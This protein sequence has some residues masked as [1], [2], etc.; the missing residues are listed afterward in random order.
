MDNQ[1]FRSIWGVAF[2]LFLSACTSVPLNSSAP[3][4][5]PQADPAVSVDPA[6]GRVSDPSAPTT[7]AVELVVK[8]S[9]APT[10]T[11]RPPAKLDER[12]RTLMEGDLTALVDALDQADPSTLELLAAQPPSEG[13]QV[14]QL[15][16]AMIQAHSGLPSVLPA[17]VPERFAGKLDQLRAMQAQLNQS[18]PRR[19]GLLLP[20]DRAWGDVLEKAFRFGLGESSVEVVVA[21]SAEPEA[22]MR[23]LVLNQGA[24][25]VICG[26]FLKRA[27]RAA[28][29]AQRYGVPIVSLAREPGM[30]SLGDRVFQVGLT[31]EAQI[32]RLVEGAMEQRNYKRFAILFPRTASG[33]SAAKRF[34]AQVEARG[35]EVIISQ[36]YPRGETTF[37]PLISGMVGRDA[38]SLNANPK[39]RKCVSEIDDELKGLRRKRR[40]ESCRDRT[41]PKVEFEAIFVPDSVASVRQIMPFIELADMVPNLNER[42]LWK[43]RKATENKELVATPILGMRQ[44]N[45]HYFASRSRTDVEGSLFVDAYYPY[46]GERALPGQFT[47]AFR[48]LNNRPP[49]LLETLAYDVG[50][51]VR[52]LDENDQLSSRSVV[53]SAL[54]QLKDFEAVTGP[55]AM[56]AE[57][58]VQRPLY[59]L[60]IHK[61]R[62]L[63]EEDRV[64]ALSEKRSKRR[65]RGR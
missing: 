32:D 8:P 31:N 38:A 2:S 42:M 23:E 15:R 5:A 46:D 40:V 63:T 53:L 3:D 9:D 55:W 7:P 19:I 24:T 56:S 29:V 58:Q 25:L 35:G 22:G 12:W 20:S 6:P 33:W 41:P 17:R 37:T 60:S 65:R 16:L 59:L 64:Q 61:R 54:S 11:P 4:G 28:V 44:L 27:K 21:S 13:Q 45:S 1:T 47:R 48:K 18:R 30:A 51:L 62:I 43:T 52:H 36:P 26:P 57:G 14:A 39:Y 10:P 50:L 49:D 34:R